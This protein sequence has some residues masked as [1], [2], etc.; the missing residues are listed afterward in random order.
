MKH[1][2]KVTVLDKKL[3]PEL[4][5]EYL[6]DPE[7]GACPCFEIGQEYLFERED[8]KDDFWHFGRDLDRSSPAQRH[9]MLSA[10]IFTRHWRAAPS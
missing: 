7:S 4:Q 5:A 9:G 3:Y 8:G 2:C 6:A 1:T 10:A